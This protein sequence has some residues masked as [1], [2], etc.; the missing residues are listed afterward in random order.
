MLIG[1]GTGG[2]VYPLIAVAN[3]I[4]KI[5]QESNAEIE[6]RALTD[7]LF[8]KK[9][10]ENAGVETKKIL[11]GKFRRYLSP[12]IL[13]DLLKMPFGFL[14]SFWLLFLFMPD[15]ILAKGGYVSFL[16]SIASKIYFIPLMIHESDSVPGLTNRILGKLAKKVFISFESAGKFF[17]AKKTALVGNPV[18]LDLA[19]GNKNN[20][21]QL[22]NLNSSKKTIL[23]VGGSQ[24]AQVINK[25]I[26]DSLVRLAGQYQIIHQVG[27]NNFESVQTEVNKIVEEGK[28]AY[29]ESIKVNYRV[30]PFLD[31]ETLKQAYAMADIVVSRAGAANLCEIS[32]LG[33]PAIVIPITKSANNH[34]VLNALEFSKFGAVVLEEAN[35]EP[36]ILLNQIE[37]LLREDTYKATSEKIRSFAKP[38]AAQ[39]IAKYVIG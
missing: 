5:S 27:A 18:R 2:H 4:K 16:P 17:S 37:N 13:L 29:D 11:A 21:A 19:A 12:K 14:Q 1:G 39:D 20:A 24:G 30:Y 23:V 3:E 9:E 8:W 34:Q 38:S 32:L 26:L 35:L 15:V 6:V 28:E 25:L 36:N 22:F 10:F 33:K 7:S 31:F